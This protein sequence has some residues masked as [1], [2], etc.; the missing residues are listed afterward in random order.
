MPTPLPVSPAIATIDQNNFLV[1]NWNPPVFVGGYAL[2]K[3]WNI[4]LAGNP[5]TPPGV[6]QLVNGHKPTGLEFAGS[7]PDSRIFQEQLISQDYGLNMQAEP[8]D[9]INY[10]DSATWNNSTTLLLFPT[11]LLP[12]DVTLDNTTLELGQTVT[13]TLANTYPSGGLGGAQYWQVNWPD[14][15]TTGPL[16][17]SNRSAAKSFTIPGAFDIE[18]VS[19]NDYSGFVPPVKLYRSLSI[20]ILVVNQQFNP[21]AGSGGSLTS[22]LGFGGTTQF[23]IVGASGTP[24]IP[25]PYSVIA[26]CLA[27]DT[28]TNELKLLALSSRFSNASS[29]LGSM[30]LDVFPLEGR[31]HA[32]ELIVPTD[33]V[34]VNANT[35]PIPVNILT[36]TLPNV[37]V[38]KSMP[39]FKLQASGGLLPYGWYNDG[40]LP[41]GLQLSIDGTITGTPTQLGTFQVNL[42]VVDSGSPAYIAEVTLSMT[43][44]TDLVITTAT[45]PN[46]IVLTPYS[47]QIASTGGLAPYTW[48]IAAGAF[49]IGIQIDPNTG[50]LFGTP[51]T[52]NSTTDY[53]TNFTATVQITDAIGAIATKTYTITLAPATLQ[54]GP[55]DQARIFAQQDFILSVPVFGGFGPYI[56]NPA[57]FVISDTFID[58]FEFVDG[59]VEIKA[60]NLDNSKTIPANATGVHQ[61]IFTA[62]AITDTHAVITP[63]TALTYAIGRRISDFRLQDAYFDHYWDSPFPVTSV[64]VNGANLLT[65]TATNDFAVGDQVL[66][67]GLG[68]A[69]FLNGQTVTILSLIGVGPVYTGFTANFTHATYGPTP[70][71][72]GT[73]VDATEVI[74][75]AQGSLQGFTLNSVVVNP[76]PANGIVAEIDATTN[77][78][79]AEA[80]GPSTTFENSEAR[81]PLQ[82]VQGLATV[83]T[84]SR[85]YTL[86]SH[87]DSLAPADV[88]SITSF[89]HTYLVG[90]FVALNPRKPYWNSPDSTIVP[91]FSP[92]PQAVNLHAQ[93]AAASAL[94]T[95]LSLDANTGLIYGILLAPYNQTS[96]IQYV[97][98]SGLVHGTVVI[99]WSTFGS[100]FT[101]ISEGG[102]DDLQ[103]GTT[104]PNG[105]PGTLMPF[106]SNGVTITGVSIVNGTSS[107][108][109]AGMFVTTDGINII[110]YGTPAEA[111]YF[112]VWFAAS[113]A[114]NGIAYA[115]ARMS[116]D[117]IVPLSILTTTLPTI[118][119]LPYS[120][121][122]QPFGGI[123]PYLWGASDGTNGPW[124]TSGVNLVAPTTGNFLG[125]QLNILTGVL[126]GTLTTPPGTSPTDLGVITFLLQDTRG[127]GSQVS[128]APGIDLVY[129][130]DLRIL[131]PSPLGVATIYAETL[132]SGPSF[133]PEGYSFDMTAIGGVPPYSWQMAVATLPTGIVFN[134]T[135]PAP[136]AAA[137]ASPFIAPGGGWF[138]GVPGATATNV[139]ETV[140]NVVTLTVAANNL[141]QIGDQVK[142]TGMTAATWLNGQQATLIA[143][144]N[145]TTLTFVDPT[146][147]GTFA[148]TPEVGLAVWSGGVSSFVPIVVSITVKDSTFPIP[149]TATGSF[150]VQ[151][152]VL[153]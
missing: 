126:S 62:G 78:A 127:L 79:Q 33:I 93:V 114:N 73:V 88:G 121:T 109:P 3:D 71:T 27:R 86:L 59:R 96:T 83:A 44:A 120:T 55:V 52:Y 54:F 68:A 146:S 124:L 95:G 151:T 13:V 111:G 135:A 108:L 153:V 18:V 45:I 39:Q 23:E 50:L 29:E 35:T 150:N 37:I 125:L 22:T 72:Q 4:W 103:S 42:A 17:L 76:P 123:P 51:C 106:R 24:V 136:F 67:A 129:N 63:L 145:A 98:S 25:Q 19:W 26:R 134:A 16:P 40:T 118:S 132:G 69:T 87:N 147:H 115:Y 77:P 41:P 80:T 89:A 110:V 53:S 130:N 43:V 60:G 148:S 152:G 34:L 20:P 31:P 38:G 141:L 140:G 102:L 91:S 9:I 49:P 113:S 15:T 143:P 1:I 117:Y 112:D 32:K 30:A 99:N 122:L 84:I 11:R 56:F 74:I 85:P 119:S 81:Y 48:A 47:Q 94:P 100:A 92:S 75:Q 107:P 64:A 5:F 66:F 142:F 2:Y 128:S 28:V 10:T 7:T 144:T 138:V 133:T 70:E 90:D 6:L 21:T 57:D 149:L 8:T 46:A 14:N 12:T 101:L 58:T 65:I 105:G 61:L 82:V 116:V 104:Y 137:T 36:T 97:D 131:T 139:S